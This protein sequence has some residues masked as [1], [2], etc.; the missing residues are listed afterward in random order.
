MFKEDP[1]PAFGIVAPLGFMTFLLP[2]PTIIP[3]V[4]LGLPPPAPS[5]LIFYIVIT[6]EFYISVLVLPLGP[7]QVL[8]LIMSEIFLGESI[9]KEPFIRNREESMIPLTFIADF[10]LCAPGKFEESSRYSFVG[11]A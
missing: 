1:G 5:L 6:D 7:Y 9:T 10:R 8:P 3:D 2:N 4:L 11:G